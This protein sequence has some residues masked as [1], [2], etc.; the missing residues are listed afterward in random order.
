M[1]NQQT[2]LYMKENRIY[3]INSGIK[4]FDFLSLDHYKLSR[5][6]DSIV[7]SKCGFQNLGITFTTKQAACSKTS[8]KSTRTALLQNTVLAKESEVSVNQGFSKTCDKDF[9]TRVLF[10]ELLEFFASQKSLLGFSKPNNEFSNFS[11]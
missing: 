2:R 9:G 4:I 11:N 10:I 1:E 5:T 3:K 7:T 6:N 8:S